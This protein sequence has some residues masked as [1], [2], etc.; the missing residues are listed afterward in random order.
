ML[1]LFLPLSLCIFISLYFSVFFN[2]LFLS[3]YFFV[4]LALSLLA[5]VWK[6]GKWK[7]RSAK[8]A[9]WQ[10]LGEQC[11]VYNVLN[12]APRGNINFILQAYLRHLD[13]KLTGR[14]IPLVSHWSPHEQGNYY[15]FE[16]L[17][18]SQYE[19]MINIWTSFTLLLLDNSDH[20]KWS[21]SWMQKI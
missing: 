17:L 21:Q 16:I 5:G 6:M 10:I 7:I 20:W 19:S 11:P 1:S 9:W 13:V 3:I 14:R 8:N 2:S 4:S 12:L 15:L 18:A